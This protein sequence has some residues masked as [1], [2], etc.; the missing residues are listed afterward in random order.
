MSY[1]RATSFE[2]LRVQLPHAPENLEP[3]QPIAEL[4]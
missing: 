3:F 2:G 1:G 4:D